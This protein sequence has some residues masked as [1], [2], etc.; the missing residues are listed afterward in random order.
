MLSLYVTLEIQ[1]RIGGETAI[2]TLL[3]HEILVR[4]FM[5]RQKVFGEISFGTLIALASLLF[6]LMMFAG[7]NSEAVLSKT[8]DIAKGFRAFLA[9][10]LAASNV[11]VKMRF[12][13][14]FRRQF[15]A[16][17]ITLKRNI[18]L[19]RDIDRLEGLVMKAEW[20]LR[21]DDTTA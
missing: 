10:M 21:C 20:D 1:R 3:I 17:P 16:A 15:Q 2:R 6:E 7:V 13:L 9:S 8:R 14:L 12:E 4:Q 19:L 11:I 18:L 5:N